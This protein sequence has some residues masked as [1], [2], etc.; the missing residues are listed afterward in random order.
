MIRLLLNSYALIF[1]NL[2][3][4]LCIEHKVYSSSTAVR[5][6]LHNSDHSRNESNGYM[7]QPRNLRGHRI[8]D[9][10][11]LAMLSPWPCYG[12]SLSHSHFSSFLGSQ[13]NL[14]KWSF[15]TSGYIYTSAAYGADG[16]IY[17]G[18]SDNKLYAIT[19]SGLLKW[20]Y[21]TGGP[22]S[23]SSP[24]LSGAPFVPRHNFLGYYLIFFFN[25][26]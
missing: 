16:T 12:M 26:M 23:Y 9:A 15:S 19:S 2:F 11:S 3:R 5:K 4:I 1:A 13:V 20:S 17:F 14:L 21:R 24:A 8:M 22:I 7:L 25:L 18:S 6:Y 10:T